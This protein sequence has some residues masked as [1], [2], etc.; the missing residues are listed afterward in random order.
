M[1]RNP[2]EIIRFCPSCGVRNRTTPA[3][4]SPPEAGAVC[5]SCR[6]PLPLAREDPLSI[7]GPLRRCPIC[8]DDKLYVQK[9]FDQRLGCLVIAAGAALV[10]W[11]YGLS[12]AVCALID[13]ALYRL[14]PDATVCYVCATRFCGPPPNP[15][16]RPY[17]L[18]MAQ[19]WE[20]R[21]I[22][23]RRRN[24]RSPGADTAGSRV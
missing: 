2:L 6:A 13:W 3:P 10:P 23:W 7:D 16:H 24:D 21:G 17:D 9:R 18:M 5:G 1:R 4:G 22:L 12:L 11:T 8:D 14:L 20:A 19:T 15:D